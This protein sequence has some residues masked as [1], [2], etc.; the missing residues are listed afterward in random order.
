MDIQSA[1]VNISQA[2]VQE[3][4]AVKIQ[5]MALDAVKEQAVALEKLLS[6]IQIINTSNMGQNVD[7]TT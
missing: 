1:S 5:A 4:A 7:I 6:S 3:E 2:K